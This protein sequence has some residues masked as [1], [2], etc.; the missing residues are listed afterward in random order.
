MDWSHT[1]LSGLLRDQIEVKLLSALV[2]LDELGVNYTTRLRIFSFTVPSSNK[3][4][5]V[6]SLVD[7]YQSDWWWTTDL[8]IQRL[9]GLL[10]LSNFLVND[11]VAHLCTH[12]IPIDNNLGWSFTVVVVL[13]GLDSL[14]QA[15]IKVLLHKLLVLSLDDDVRVVRGLMLVGRGNESNYTLLSS[16]T[17]I[18]SN[19]HDL[20]LV[21][22]LRQFDPH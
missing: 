7:N 21:H 6:D 18:N 3:H 15:A 22:K 12:T 20:F 2:V 11:L 9:E 16:V 8:V 1:T 17:H 14:D 4:S 13:E 5:L 19:D 10:E